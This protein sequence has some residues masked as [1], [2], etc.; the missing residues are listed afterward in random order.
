MPPL[1][2]APVLPGAKAKRVNRR[3]KQG[4]SP[5]CPRITGN[6]AARPRVSLRGNRLAVPRRTR[7]QAKPLEIAQAGCNRPAIRAARAWKGKRAHFQGNGKQAGQW[8]SPPLPPSFREWFSRCR[9]SVK[10]SFRQ[11]YA[12]LPAS[13]APDPFPGPQSFVPLHVFPRLGIMVQ[14]GLWHICGP[15][16]PKGGGE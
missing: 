6:S 13:L 8:L 14:R 12:Q 10:P 4:N 3:W 11:R 9:L 15:I 1:R 16:I 2:V 5:T 7:G